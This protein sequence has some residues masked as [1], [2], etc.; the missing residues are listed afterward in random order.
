MEIFF[1]VRLNI[2]RIIKSKSNQI[3]TNQRRRRLSLNKV[4]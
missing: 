4:N 2:N 1:S 3:E